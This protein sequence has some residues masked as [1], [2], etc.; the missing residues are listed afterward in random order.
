MPVNSEEEEEREGG[1]SDDGMED[2]RS[3]VSLDL[4]TENADFVSLE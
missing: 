2:Y 1:G 3:V 4:I